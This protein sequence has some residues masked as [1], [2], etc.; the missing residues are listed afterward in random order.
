MAEEI[1]ERYEEAYG[2]LTE[3]IDQARSSDDFRLLNSLTNWIV[4]RARVAVRL[5]ASL[6]DSSDPAQRERALQLMRET[7]AELNHRAFTVSFLAPSPGNNQQ[8]SVTHFF[9]LRVQIEVL[10]KLGE[11]EL[12]Q[13]LRGDALRDFNKA[14][15]VLKD[16]IDYSR[17]SANPIPRSQELTL[18][19]TA[20]EGPGQSPGAGHGKRSGA[21]GRSPGKRSSSVIAGERGLG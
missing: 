13:G 21:S 12:A 17:A 6:G 2:D 19:E 16:L 18:R 4:Q 11:V 20:P 10:L 15:K 1:L 14:G 7:A 9:Y 5:A 8:A 3:L